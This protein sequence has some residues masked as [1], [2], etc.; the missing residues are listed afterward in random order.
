[1]ASKMKCP[2]ARNPNRRRGGGGWSV[3]MTEG[4]REMA[5]WLAG[6]TVVQEVVRMIHF[7][8]SWHPETDE[9]AP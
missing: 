3:A 7:E 1:M 2:D 4:G 9:S 6:G 8:L 5:G